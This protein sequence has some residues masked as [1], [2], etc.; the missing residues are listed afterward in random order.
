[1]RLTCRML[2]ACALLIWLAPRTRSQEPPKP[3]A[4]HEHLK[5]MEGTWD[6]TIKAGFVRHCFNLGGK[7]PALGQH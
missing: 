2:L 6:A 3:G 5:Q 1:M 4:E 7:L